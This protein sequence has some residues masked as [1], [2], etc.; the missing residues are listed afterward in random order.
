MKPVQEL[1]CTMPCNEG[2][3]SPAMVAIAHRPYNQL[4]PGYL[5][6]DRVGRGILQCMP[7]NVPLLEP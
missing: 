3:C 2:G 7:Q 1:V 6:E 5:S 4:L